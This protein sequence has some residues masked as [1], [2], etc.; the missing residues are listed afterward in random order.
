MVAEKPTRTQAPATTPRLRESRS[1]APT[2]PGPTRQ[3]KK[4]AIALFLSTF[5]TTLV[6]L[7]LTEH[8][9]VQSNQL[10]LTRL[11]R[12]VHQ[13]EQ[14]VKDLDREISTLQLSVPVGEFVHA[15]GMVRTGTDLN[16]VEIGSGR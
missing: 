7:Y 5:L 10:K 1:P 11:E 12:E 15:R 13:A 4:M 2:P 14:A 8:A 16:V 9:L 6:V 3:T